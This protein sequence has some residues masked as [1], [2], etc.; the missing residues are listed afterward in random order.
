MV[1]FCDMSSSDRP[2]SLY[3][4]I[5]FC[6][7]RCTYCA[8]NTYTGLDDLIPAYSAMLA[9]EMSL[10]AARGAGPF[11]PA[12]TLY[13][14]GGTPS[15]L[16]PEQV[17][18][19]IEAAHQTFHLQPDAEITLEANPGTVDEARFAGFLE[20]G[21]T[22]VSIG[23]QSAHQA[24]LGMFGRDHTFAE[25]AEAFS[26]AR[27]AGFTNIS[28]DLIYGAPHQTREAWRQT[29]DSVL[30]W[31]PDHISLYSLTLEPGTRLAWLVEQHELPSPDPDLAADM[32]E[33]ARDWMARGGLVQYEISNWARPGLECRHNRQ[34]WVNNPYFGFGAGAHG[35]I[36]GKR[37]WNVRPIRDYMTRVDE[38]R[39]TEPSL[40]PAVDGWDQIGEPMAM[41][42]MFMLNLR[43]V[44][45]GL[46]LR[47]FE[48]RFG[49]PADQVFGREIATLEQ[50]GLLRRSGDTLRLD[51]RAYLLSNRVFMRFMPDD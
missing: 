37:Y 23:V 47:Q 31:G 18:A 24:D 29:L 12:H 43:L 26:A 25:A 30:S 46:D 2:L 36:N 19:L 10:A 9:R 45:E 33:D 14:G 32:Y 39:S 4:H 11:A 35:F 22:R 1:Q 5:P 50:Q 21:V 16:A 49:A 34:Y 42:E 44:A 40:S 15:L 27:R 17:G 20:A 3:L 41:A 28:V 51:Q 38:A 13:F 8:F 7:S 48:T 6:K